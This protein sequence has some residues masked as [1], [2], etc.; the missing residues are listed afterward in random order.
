MKT[1]LKVILILLAAGIV[2]G[3]FWLVVNNT[4]LATAGSGQ[5]PGEGLGRPNFEGG[6]MPERFD[7]RTP[8]EGFEGQGSGAGK[9]QGPGGGEGH[10]ASLWRGLTEV[11]GILVKLTIVIAVVL[12]IQKAV[13]WIS[14][15]RRPGR[16]SL[17]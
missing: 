5:G 3:G 17:A 1:L 13:A 9:G 7:G 15:K 2:A 4:S 16:P 14:A 10:S 11:A 8:P 6:A 12:L